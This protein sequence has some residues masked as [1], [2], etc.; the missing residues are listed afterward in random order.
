MQL[1]CVCC[2]KNYELDQP[3]G[4]VR[5]FY[6]VCLE[7]EENAPKSEL[8]QALLDMVKES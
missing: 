6:G 2:G 1:V 7:C 3:Q 5:G 4:F 8:T